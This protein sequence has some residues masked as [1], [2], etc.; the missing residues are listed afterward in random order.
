MRCEPDSMGPGRGPGAGTTSRFCE[1]GA[2][3][4]NLWNSRGFVLSLLY[5]YHLSSYLLIT[6]LQLWIKLSRTGSSV[7]SL[8]H[9][10]VPHHTSSIPTYLPIRFTRLYVLHVRMTYRSLSL[11]FPGDL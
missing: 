11:L 8:L 9:H 4:L 6:R 1:V 5:Q 7:T 10:T 3:I 2:Q